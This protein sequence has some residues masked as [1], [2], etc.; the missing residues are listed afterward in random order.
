MLRHAVE[1]YSQI[2]L[3]EPDAAAEAPLDLLTESVELDLIKQMAEWP[4][5]VEAAAQSYEPHRIAFYLNDLAASFHAFWNMGKEDA[6]L[7]FLLKDDLR[8]TGARLALIQAVA[9]VIASGLKV[10]GV[11][12][13]E[14]MR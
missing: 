13:V 9:T 2:P 10:L 12:P 4:R 5:T 7:R 14:E 6:S 3:G 11:T 8:L 1:E